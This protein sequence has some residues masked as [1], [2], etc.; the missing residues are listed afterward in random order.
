MMA[1]G[2]FELKRFCFLHRQHKDHILRLFMLFW[3]AYNSSER[4][5]TIFEAWLRI[6]FIIQYDFLLFLGEAPSSSDV[7]FIYQ[8]T[9]IVV[10]LITSKGAPPLI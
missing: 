9:L 3:I 2:T 4:Y 7:Q 1:E 5:C 6:Y 10:K 8:A